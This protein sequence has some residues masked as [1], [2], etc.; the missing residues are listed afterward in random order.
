M[1]G[2]LFLLSFR[3]EQHVNVSYYLTATI[4]AIEVSY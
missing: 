4:V 2:S 1:C 3:D